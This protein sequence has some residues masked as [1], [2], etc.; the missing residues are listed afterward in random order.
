M[1]IRVRHVSFH[2]C[3]C[4][5]ICRGHRITLGV[6][7]HCPPCL[8]VCVWGCGS[9]IGLELCQTGW[10]SWLVS[11][12][13][14]PSPPPH[15]WDYR[16]VFLCRAFYLWGWVLGRKL[17]SH[18]QMAGTL[19]TGNVTHTRITNSLGSL[20]HSLPLPSSLLSSVSQ[21]SPVYLRLALNMPSS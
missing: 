20:C 10:A 11:P 6:L 21:H 17:G 5:C 9:L 18:T 2:V 14:L 12:G 7:S 16:C 13:T 8:C 1:S 3:G 15:F 19:L 4:A